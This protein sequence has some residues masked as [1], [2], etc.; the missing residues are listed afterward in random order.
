MKYSIYLKRC[1]DLAR[2]GNGRVSPNPS[3]GSVIVADNEIIGE[4]WHEEYGKAHAEVNAVKS[5]REKSFYALSYSKIFVSLEPCFHF[6]KTPPCVDLILKENIPNV[7]IAFKDPNPKVGGKSITKLRNNDVNV[8]LFSNKIGFMNQ[9]LNNTLK[10][11]FTNIQKQKP[12]II[13]KWAESA[14]N[15]IGIDSQT[16]QISNKYSQRLVHKWRSECDGI[17]VG[18]KTAQIDN[19]S[20][21]NRFYFGKSPIRIVIDRN[22][23]LRKNLNIFKDSQKTLVYTEGVTEFFENN[24]VNPVEYVNIEF[25]D[26]SVHNILN[27]LFSRKI[28]ILFVEGG[29]QTLQNFIDSGLW[30]EARVIKNPKLFLSNNGG[31]SAPHLKNFASENRYELDDNEIT[32]YK[33]F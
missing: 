1:F 32:V 28:N 15:C 4:G 30:N 9:E 3:V 21:N 6:G 22:L 8:T 11:F 17:L 10:P 26:K 16:S 18:T 29:A 14:D 25:G 23:K 33:N 13:L 5:V 2:L 24:D 20:L 31:I 27:N 19:P 12:Y 7:V